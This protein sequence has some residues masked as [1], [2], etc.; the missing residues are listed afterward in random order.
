MFP[1]LE[2]LQRSSLTSV[3]SSASVRS[4][5]GGVGRAAAGKHELQEGA[6]LGPGLH[7]RRYRYEDLHT[8]QLFPHACWMIC[9]AT[10]ASRDLNFSPSAAQKVC[11]LLGINVTDFT[12]AILS[13]RIKVCWCLKTY[14]SPILQLILATV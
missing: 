7:A 11:H 8:L 4:V 14:S 6:S 10:S 12:R 3:T 9:R 5:E 1:P 13:P 2:R